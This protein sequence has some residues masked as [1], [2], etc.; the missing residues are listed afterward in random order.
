MSWENF[1]IYR[2]LEELT[3]DAVTGLDYERRMTMFSDNLDFITDI[4]NF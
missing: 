1:A 3:D 4:M 2:W